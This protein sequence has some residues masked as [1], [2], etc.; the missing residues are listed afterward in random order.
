MVENLASENRLM[1]RTRPIKLTA[2]LLKH[3][4]PLTRSS[5]GV[6]HGR[7][8]PPSVVPSLCKVNFLRVT[9]HSARIGKSYRLI[10]ADTSLVG[11]CLCNFW[12]ITLTVRSISGP[13]APDVGSPGECSHQDATVTCPAGCRVSHQ[14]DRRCLDYFTELLKAG[15]NG[16]SFLPAIDHSSLLTLHCLF[17]SAGQLTTTVIGSG[18]A[19][20]AGTSIRKRWPSRETA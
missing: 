3:W 4:T 19:S 13:E 20:P 16:K 6:L 10:N 14:G 7:S 18:L 8:T 11:S 15:C 9:R 5:S 2:S 12:C 17:S 1:S